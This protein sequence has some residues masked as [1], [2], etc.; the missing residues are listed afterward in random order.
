MHK[1][2]ITVFSLALVVLAGPA[3]ADVRLPKVFTDHMVLQQQ[4]P[5]HVWGWAESGESVTV[6]LAD[7]TASAEAG[8][9]G[10][11]QVELPAMD[12]D[13]R[14]HTLTVKAANTIELKD[15]LLGELWICAGQSNMN[16]EVE[17][18]EPLP[19]MRVFWIHGSTAPRQHDL[20]DNAMGWEPADP[21]RLAEVRKVRQKRFHP[22][23]KGGFAEVGWVFGR[24]VHEQL[25]VPVGLIK[26]A[27]G[28]SQARAWTPV[29]NIAEQFPFDQKVEGSYLG[30]KPG[31]LY[32]S[33]LHGL[34]PLSVRGVVWYQGENNGR[35]WNY[36]DE[37]AAM[38][39]SWRQRFKQ[40]QMPFYLAQIAQ[41]TYASGMER[42]WECQAKVAA[43]VP[44]VYLGASNDLWDGGGTQRDR[45]RPDA[46]KNNAPGTGWPI[47]GT[48]NPHPPNKHIVANRLA[49]IA[50][51]ET[52][53]VDLGREVFA[54][55]YD[56][57]RVEGDKILVKFKHVGD[58][59][60]T[61]DGQPPNWLEISDGTRQQDR[62]NAPLRY[63]KAQ[64]KIVGKDTVEVRADDVKAP[65]HVRLGW[66]PLARHNLYNSDGVPAINFRTDAQPT[67]KR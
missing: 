1:T 49:D 14:P 30:H 62:D 18:Q 50:L 63:T 23:H 5:I 3:M 56:S 29:P 42:V 17:I 21:Q 15:V 2:G 8:D 11:W 57:H 51:A 10:R 25:K 32:Q 27:F 35:D 19:Q 12:A 7:K 64:A 28:G 34:P 65:K 48:S 41:T 59:L 47:A 45:I 26:S 33:M 66:H 37:L 4:M 6:G 52:Y 39:A 44:Q 31:L 55:V 13:G 46:G 20:G 61:D 43:T 36:D 38:I 53:G 54:P 9:D 58:G 16:R 60:K 22:S 24:R 40:P 67:K